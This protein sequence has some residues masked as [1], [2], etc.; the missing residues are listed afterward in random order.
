LSKSA[1]VRAELRP[2]LSVKDAMALSSLSHATIHKMIAARVIQSAKVGGK[3]LIN[4]ESLLRVLTEGSPTPRAPE[5]PR[6][7]QAR[8]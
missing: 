5:P 6:P 1:T 2:V 8:A 4:C 7:L 3:R